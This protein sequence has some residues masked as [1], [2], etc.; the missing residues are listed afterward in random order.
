[1]I[2]RYAEKRTIKGALDA[3]G[4]DIEP[5]QLA[6]Q[7]AIEEAVLDLIDDRHGPALELDL[8]A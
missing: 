7:G 3:L 4:A 1:M 6:F 2:D 8:I 5:G